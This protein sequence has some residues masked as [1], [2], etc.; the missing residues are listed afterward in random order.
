MMEKVARGTRIMISVCIRQYWWSNSL[1]SK[2]KLLVSEDLEGEIRVNGQRVKLVLGN[3]TLY[4]NDL[5]KSE[6]KSQAVRNI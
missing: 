1:L 4:L 5:H 2:L 3:I 6:E